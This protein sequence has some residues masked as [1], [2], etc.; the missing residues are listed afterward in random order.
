MYVMLNFEGEDDD[1]NK[2]IDD[3]DRIEDE[4]F[5][6]DDDLEASSS[7]GA[8]AG[9]ILISLEGEEH[10]YTLH[11]EVSASNNEAEYEA[12][13]SGLRIAE[14]M[15]IKALKVS[16]DSQLVSNQMNEMFEARDPAM[17]TYL[18]LAEEMAN[19][20]ELF[21]ITQVPRSMNKKADAFNKLATS[22]FSHFTKDVWVEVLSQ[23]S[24]NVLQEVAPVEE[25]ETWMSPITAYLKHGTL[26]VNGAAARKIR[27]K[28]PFKKFS[29][30][31][32]RS[33]C[34]GLNIKQNFSSVAHPQANGQVEV[35]NIDIVT[36]IR[37]RL[38]TDRKGL[39]D[40]LPQVLWVFRTTSKGSNRETPFSLV[41]GSEA[42]KENLDLLEER[43]ELAAIIYYNRRVKERTFCPGDYVWRNNNASWVE[44]TGKLG[45]NWKSSYVVVEALGNGAYNLKTHDG[46]F[47][48]RT[49]HATNLK[50]FYV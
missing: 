12:L 16:V 27:M 35:T 32:F 39:V 48:P 41:Y 49:W 6:D 34:N 42:L 29:H 37:A 4:K 5:Q 20:F 47:V 45:P 50:E 43:R 7:D 11:F 30:D 46:K 18:K 14:K 15:G 19:K 38:D 23:K 33:W 24:T 22:I 2:Y 10:T 36:G 21:S 28:A 13:L 31:S 9:L 8:G 17:Q 26:P 3:D 25:V 40:E 1:N 44:D